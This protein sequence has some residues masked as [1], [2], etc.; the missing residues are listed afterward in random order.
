M[1][2]G[3]QAD[4]GQAEEARGDH[5]VEQPGEGEAE[6]ALQG[7]H[8]VVGAM[9]NFGDRGVGE[10]G[11]QWREVT[12]SQRVEEHGFPSVAGHLQETHLLLVVMQ[13]VRLA[14]EGQRA[15]ALE[16][17][18]ERA[19]LVCATNPGSHGSVV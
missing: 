8:V 12:Q 7:G 16:T 3:L 14:V 13:A 6:V 1:G 4:G 9:K 11:A 18:D 5:G 10:D 2:H 19:Q 15:A 17:R